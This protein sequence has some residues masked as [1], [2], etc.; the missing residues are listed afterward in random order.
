MDVSSIR[1][2]C[3]DFRLKKDFYFYSDMSGE[4]ASVLLVNHERG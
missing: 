1:L 2:L 4:N 3:N